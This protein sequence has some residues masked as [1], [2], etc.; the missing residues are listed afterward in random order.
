MIIDYP[1]NEAAISLLL[2]EYKNKVKNGFYHTLQIQF[3]Y[4]SNHIE[5][6][7]LTPEQTQTIFDKGVIQGQARVQDIAEAT[8]HFRLLDY[9]LDTLEKEL[10]EELIREFHRLLKTN[11]DNDAGEYKRYNNQIGDGIEP[12]AT[13]AA[14]KVPQA[15]RELLNSYSNSVEQKTLRDLAAF[16]H[17][18]EAI[19]PFQDGNGRVGRVILFRECIRNEVTPFIVQDLY[20]NFYY[21]GLR[22]WSSG[23][24]QRLLET[25]NMCQELFYQNSRYFLGFEDTL[26]RAD[27][28]EC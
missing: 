18:F 17:N 21:Q 15:M 3:A 6:S 13:C 26:L 5:G 10:S 27:G 2:D 28:S 8:N 14:S 25:F 16:H 9:M 4:N 11:I 24:E 7:T 22:E 12:V 20:K 23:K 19:H 1:Y